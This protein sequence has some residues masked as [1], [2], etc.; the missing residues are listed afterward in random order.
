MSF[1]TILFT[2]KG[3]A[4][5]SKALAGANLNFT[6]IVMGSG[7]LGGQSQITLSAV[8]EPKV[9][10]NI[11]SLQH[12]SNYATVKGVFSNSD[13][14]EGF[15]WRELGVYA[16]DP[17]LGEILYCYGNAGALADYIP[18][19]SSEIIEKVVSISV[20][21]GNVANVTATIDESLVY[22]SKA[23]LDAKANASDVNSAL[24]QKAN[25]STV[26]SVTASVAGWSGA[27]APFT[28]IINV[29]GVT[30]ESNIYIAIGS[31]ATVT[32]YAAA[33]DAQLHCSA[34]G[35]GTITLKAFDTKPTVAIPLTVLILG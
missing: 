26:I 12:K 14:S 23:D 7:N 17:D 10:L 25:K 35:A 4:L 34:Q 31:G 8:I 22:A 15:Y 13:I 18:S 32:E 30:A 3:R 16:Q 21:V 29:E 28:N 1:S 2:D 20:I 33:V 11:T 24:A 9:N 27:S 5:Q 6:K 19:Q